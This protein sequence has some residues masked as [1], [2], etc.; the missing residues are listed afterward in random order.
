MK[1]CR[2]VEIIT[3]TKI[4]LNCGSDHGVKLNFRFIIYGL[5]KPLIDPVTNEE[6]GQAEIIRGEGTVTHVQDKLCTVE[7][8]LFK[9]GTKRIIRKTNPYEYGST[10]EEEIIGEKKRK[11]F[12]SV[13]IGDYAKQIKE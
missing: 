10:T 1:T 2:V 3:K 8:T 7:S 6:L 5:S 11:E 13:Q 4:I 12:D 9:E